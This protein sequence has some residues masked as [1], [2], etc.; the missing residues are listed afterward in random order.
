MSRNFPSVT[1]RVLRPGIHP[2]GGPGRRFEYNEDIADFEGIE[3]MREMMEMQE[4]MEII[5]IMEIL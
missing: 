4:I 3:D 5:I 1:F 2:W